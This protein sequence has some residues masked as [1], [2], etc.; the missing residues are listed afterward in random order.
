MTGRRL[1]CSGQQSC[2]KATRL[3]FIKRN[4][5]LL[6][7]TRP[8]ETPNKTTAFRVNSAAIN[9]P[10]LKILP[11]TTNNAIGRVGFA[12]PVPPHTMTPTSSPRVTPLIPEED[13]L[14]KVLLRHSN[15]ASTLTVPWWRLEKRKDG[16]LVRHYADAKSEVLSY[17]QALAQ[18]VACAEWYDAEILYTSYCQFGDIPFCLNHGKNSPSHIA[19]KL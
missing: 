5:L 10:A 4:L 15:G 18:T 17:Q 14:S 11:R 12:L 19:V 1:P 9:S 8:T 6:R 16:M 3:P 2:K 13:I 7:K